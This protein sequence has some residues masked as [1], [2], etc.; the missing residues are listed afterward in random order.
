MFQILTNLF[1]ISHFAISFSEIAEVWL[2]TIPDDI[3]A[4]QISVGQL[5]TVKS[6]NQFGKIGNMF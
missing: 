6:E 3:A 2:C 1:Q 4:N 5:R